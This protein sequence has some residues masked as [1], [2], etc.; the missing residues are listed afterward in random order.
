MRIPLILALL[1]S[2]PSAWSQTTWFVA[3]G[4][5]N[6]GTGLPG[7]PYSSIQFALAAPTTAAGDTILVAPG[8]Y[9]ERLD[10]LG[11]DVRVAGVGDA[12]RTLLVGGAGGSVVTFRTGESAAAVLENFTIQGGLASGPV[13]DTRGGGIR[14]EN[15]SPTILRC[16]ITGN[17]AH[18]GGGVA[19]E[20]GSPTFVECGI[21][22]NTITP[23]GTADTF[24]A[25]V[26]AGIGAQPRFTDCRID[27]NDYGQSTA[28]LYGGGACG[29]G[30]YLRCTF[31][32][33]TA[34]EGAGVHADQ[35]APRLVD[36]FVRRNATGNAA[37][38]C[39]VGAGVR[40]P[41]LCEDTT[42]LKNRGCSEGGA[43]YLCTLVRCSLNEN[44]VRAVGGMPALGGGASR[45][46]MTE[47]TLLENFAR[48]VLPLDSGVASGGGGSYEGTATDCLY[49]DNVAE[50]GNGGGAR[51]TRLLRC[52][53]SANAALPVDPGQVALGGG[54][55]EGELTSCDVWGNRA[56]SGGGCAGSRLDRCTVV[57]NEAVLSGGGFAE[58][59]AV[60]TIRNS[61][62]RD[63]RPDQ[64]RAV[65]QAPLV[66][67]S[68]VAGGWPGLGNF[69]ADPQFFAPMTDDH[70]LKAGSPCIDAGDPAV[71][72]PDGS[73]C[74][75]GAYPYDPSW[76]GEPRTWCEGKTN[77]QGC[78]PGL[79]VQGSTALSGPDDLRIVASEFVNWTSGR[80][81]W[82]TGAA[83][84]PFQGGTLCLAS[85]IQRGRVASTGGNDL[86]LRD[87]SGSLRI[88][89]THSWLAAN[90]YG[91]GT[92]LYFQFV[93][94]D[95]LNA[96]G[97][98][99][100][101]SN[102]VELT[103]C[104]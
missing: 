30:T 84:L 57:D 102:A 87:C 86:P 10:F 8:T 98:G 16:E 91:P 97:T 51:L 11:K 83:Q 47:C 23:G 39:G 36:C 41:A 75:V 73:R 2:A 104:P 69:D 7:D 56:T 61:I 94:R 54:A 82:S 26:Y 89:V 35:R 4:G 59:T 31:F 52:E 96:D 25:G 38:G 63:N 21:T 76:C 53:L 37:G 33:N 92:T 88:D 95:R 100:S 93:A 66:A 78:V 62:L 77:S 1:A 80:A 40:G 6:P 29:G 55:Y 72:D 49:L 17:R 101:L 28:N 103:I 50:R 43:A 74:D 65:L 45:C 19:I 99:Y 71:F 9:L 70:R 58:T 85:P 79:D 32:F 3:A 14:I 44:E 48:G 60:A 12:T 46:D 34:F 90:G 15:A 81:C 13:P 24:G 42:F 68:D 22:Y 5:S 27:R 64:I 20:N 67:Y 18:R